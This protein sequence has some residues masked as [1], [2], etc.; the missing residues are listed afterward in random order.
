M[1]SVISRVGATL[2]FTDE[3][4]VAHPVQHAL[5]KVVVA[6]ELCSPGSVFEQRPL[7]CVAI[8][9]T[10]RGRAEA[11]IGGTLVCYDSRSA[12]MILPGL[13]LEE[14]VALDT[15]WDVSYVLLQGTWP[16]W[17]CREAAEPIVALQSPPTRLAELVET[18]LD[19][20][21]S[22]FKPEPWSVMG[23]VAELIGIF[24]N[25][26]A[27][28]SSADSLERSV[29]SVIDNDPVEFVCRDQIAARLGMTTRA[30]AYR[31]QSETGQPL[32]LW[33]RRRRI[34]RAGSLL[35][36]G[37]S[38]GSVADILGFAN[39]YHFS[40]VFKSITGRSPSEVRAEAIADR[41]HS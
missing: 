35:A 4:D 36:Q 3:M 19:L 22:G 8:V 26:Q 32:A 1:Q 18:L 25:A 16:E 15:A 2:S 11:N 17:L 12:A 41:F 27:Q 20:A 39:P 40:R 23:A 38:V 6:R 29:A 14:R 10:H 37:R 21:V 30:L 28:G 24:S 34:I 13:D 7:S 33:L 31:F 5:T 9:L